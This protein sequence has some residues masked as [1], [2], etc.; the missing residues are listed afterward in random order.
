MSMTALTRMVWLWMALYVTGKSDK[1][2]MENGSKKPVFRNYIKIM[3]K[4]LDA[5]KEPNK[6]GL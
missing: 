6:L 1:L 2:K 4:L 3:K 5:N